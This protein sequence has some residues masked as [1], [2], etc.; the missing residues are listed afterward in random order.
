MTLSLKFWDKEGEPTMGLRSPI[1]CEIADKANDWYYYGRVEMKAT[2]VEIAG[3]ETELHL[4]G[5]LNA[6]HAKE[7]KW[8][9]STQD[10]MRTANQVPY[11]Q[12]RK[13]RARLLQIF[14]LAFA[15]V[16]LLSLYFTFL[17]VQAGPS[18]VFYSSQ[19]HSL[20]WQ[21]GT[22]AFLFIFMAGAWAWTA[23]YHHF[24]SDWEIQPL[25]DNP[26]EFK[27]DF[28]ILTN[29]TKNLVYKTV[30]ELERLNPQGVETI[31]KTVQKL[32]MQEVDSWKEI[33]RQKDN[34]V[35]ELSVT[36]YSI[37]EDARNIS[38]LTKT[39][40]Q[41]TRQDR[42][43]IIFVAVGATLIGAVVSYFVFLLGG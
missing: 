13:G 22:V 26:S 17:L 33:A 15:S 32:Q 8:I 16:Y 23:R 30:S 1:D 6:E 20:E 42:A 27:H 19:L 5:L 40:L 18:I 39:E 37:R 4:Y 31:C 24:V 9:V 36:G 3:K 35:D 41:Q 29:S 10:M 25:D 43:K 21:L 38:L 34:T 14:V 28:Y 12:S 2:R 11:T 7:K